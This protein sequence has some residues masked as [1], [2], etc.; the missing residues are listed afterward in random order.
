MN[1]TFYKIHPH[2]R[3][4]PFEQ[5]VA[6]MYDGSSTITVYVNKIGDIIQ[7]SPVT[8]TLQEFDLYFEVKSV[9]PDIDMV[10]T[11]RDIFKN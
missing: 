9:K 8:M 7:N 11:L 6:V 1:S 3:Y 2:D 10:K 4:D 5:G